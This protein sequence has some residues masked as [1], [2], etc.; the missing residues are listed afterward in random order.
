MPFT[1]SSSEAIISGASFQRIPTGMVEVDRVLRLF[2]ENKELARGLYSRFVNEALTETREN[3]YY[4]GV[5]Q[6]ILGD[7]KFI[8][9]A[10]K[11][12]RLTEKPVRKPSIETLFKEVENLTSVK[13]EEIIARNRNTQTA[14]ARRLFV[15]VWRVSGGETADLQSVLKRDISTLSKFSR[16]ADSSKGREAMKKLYSL[17]QA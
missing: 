13:R 3:S 12:I 9:K 4:K 5:E 15:G 7:E 10:A 11:A 17:I 8:E 2:S 1:M 6:Q 14:F 16:V